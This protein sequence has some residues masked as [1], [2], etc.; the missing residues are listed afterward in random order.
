VFIV[1]PQ[2]GSS[3]HMPTDLLGFTAATYD[4]DFAKTNVNGALGA[5]I[6]L[7][8]QAIRASPWAARRLDIKSF[9]SIKEDAN[10]PLK[11]NL[12]IKNSEPVPVAIQSNEF[13]FRSVAQRASNAE[14]DRDIYRPKFRVGQI[15]KKDVY[16]SQWLLLPERW[17]DSWVPFDPT[18]GKK[19]LESLAKLKQTGIWRFRCVWLDK[20]PDAQIYE[21]KL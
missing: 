21:E 10:W 7:V 12:R 5:A 13:E 18:M 17:I 16:E 20:A 11:L 8:R 2:G 15:D 9:A 4:P 14:L 19:A 6:T 1:I 3:F